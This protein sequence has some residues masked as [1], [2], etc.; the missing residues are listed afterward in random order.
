MKRANRSNKLFDEKQNHKR[1][2]RKEAVEEEE[3][4][5]EAEEDSGRESEYDLLLEEGAGEK[6]FGIDSKCEGGKKDEEVEDE[7]REKTK[8]EEKNK[9]EEEQEEKEAWENILD[10]DIGDHSIEEK[11][12]P[13]VES[14]Q[15]NNSL[16]KHGWKTNI[17]TS[18]E[19]SSAKES[20][21]SYSV[22]HVSYWTHGL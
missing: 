16:P 19:F 3:K 22:I 12:S 5:E 18:S 14:G 8:E 2:K 11:D 21:Q 10:L 17:E 6:N 20:Q 15:G 1:D 7:K 13:L 4:V 9:E